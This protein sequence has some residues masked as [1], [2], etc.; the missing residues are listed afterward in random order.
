MAIVV[1]CLTSKH[2]ARNSNPST[3]QTKTKPTDQIKGQQQ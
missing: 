3:T 1:D 2:K